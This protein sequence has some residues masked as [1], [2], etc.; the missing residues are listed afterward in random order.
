MT[1][2]RQLYHLVCL[3]ILGCLTG[4]MRPDRAAPT[5]TAAERVPDV[6]GLWSSPPVVH[7]ATRLDLQ[8]KGNALSGRAIIGDDLGETNVSVSGTVSRDLVVLQVHPTPRRDLGWSGPKRFRVT[9]TVVRFWLA[10]HTDF[11]TNTPEKVMFLVGESGVDAPPG[12]QEQL[13]RSD[14]VDA[15][16]KRMRNAQP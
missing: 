13:W 12:R 2:L 11:V 10:F 7:T 8:Q 1:E 14:L 15:W 3:L 5:G 6:S 4:C 9:N 16:D